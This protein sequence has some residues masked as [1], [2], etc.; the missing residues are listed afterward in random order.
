MLHAYSFLDSKVR[1]NG[2]LIFLNL[3]FVC[4]CIMCIILFS[5]CK[6]DNDGKAESAALLSNWLNDTKLW[7]YN[8]LLQSLKRGMTPKIVNFIK[9]RLQGIFNCRF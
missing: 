3:Y 5:D 9:C 6:I 1:A 8:D 7:Q 2:K 4:H